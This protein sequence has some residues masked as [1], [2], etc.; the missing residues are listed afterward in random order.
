MDDRSGSKASLIARLTKDDERAKDADFPPP[1][2]DNTQTP[3][4]SHSSTSSLTSLD[5][6]VQGKEGCKSI[7]DGCDSMPQSDVRQNDPDRSPTLTSDSTVKSNDV[8]RPGKAG[9]KGK[10]GED[11]D[12]DGGKDTDEKDFIN[13][14]D[15]EENASR[16]GNSAIAVLQDSARVAGSAEVVIAAPGLRESDKDIGTAIR[17]SCDN[18]SWPDFLNNNTLLLGNSAGT[19]EEPKQDLSGRTV[20]AFLFTPLGSSLC[21]NSN[22]LMWNKYQ[23]TS[24]QILGSL[25]REKLVQSLYLNTT[26]ACA[27]AIQSLENPALVALQSRKMFT[28]IANKV[29]HEWLH[30]LMQGQ[31]LDRCV[32][33]TEPWVLEDDFLANSA[34]DMES[35]PAGFRG[36]Y[37]SC[38]E[39]HNVVAEASNHFTVH[40]D[41]VNEGNLK[42]TVE[43]RQDA[44]D[45]AVTSLARRLA[46][47]K[48]A[49]KITIIENN[50]TA[51]A[52]GIRALVE[53][54]IR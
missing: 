14:D 26:F 18:F 47:G 6:P 35:V 40:E 2:G 48:N 53:V 13:P 24:P 33:A 21:Y 10:D 8:H 50:F 9:A 28:P 11:G 23:V 5:E 25:D 7:T 39:W 44:N 30:V 29:Q 12:E 32:W 52:L 17:G 45:T 41:M 31:S 34:P 54:S 51:A 3:H 22:P 19:S 20:A 16:N 42:Y 38:Q 49:E 46:Q 37:C 43:G 27:R 15:E 36:F 1:M 4:D